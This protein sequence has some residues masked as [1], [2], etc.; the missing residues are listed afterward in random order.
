M[1]PTS[2]RP[3]ATA[4]RW[5]G[6]R[7]AP[8]APTCWPGWHRW[9][10]SR[11]TGWWIASWPLAPLPTNPP[12]A[13]LA[14]QPD[15]ITRLAPGQRTLL[16]EQAQRGALAA[17]QLML[18]L[19]WPV[20][21]PGPWQ[22]SALN[23]AAFRGDAAMVALLLQHG[24]RWHEENGY[25]GNAL[26]SCLHAGCHEPVAGGDYAEVLR[27]LLA[28]GAP[29]PEVDGHWPDEMAAVVEGLATAG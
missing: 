28:D 21:V 9:G 11:P 10:K 1:A 17:V 26:G 14:Q 29:R 3:T 2:P 20:D 8:A 4:T 22:A 13:L 16:P 23:Q 5:P 27:L 19:G 18:A 15:L 6:T 12:R 24:A 25:G 7:H